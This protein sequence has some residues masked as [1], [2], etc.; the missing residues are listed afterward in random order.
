MGFLQRLRDR[1]ANHR[2]RLLD[3]E[4]RR[5]QAHSGIQ[6]AATDAAGPILGGRVGEVEMTITDHSPK[7]VDEP[8]E[9]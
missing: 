6:P 2:K 9:R 1:R 3:H 4:L 5:E 8:P 7:D